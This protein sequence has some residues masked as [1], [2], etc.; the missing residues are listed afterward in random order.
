MDRLGLGKLEGFSDG[1]TVKLLILEGIGVIIAGRTGET[2]GIPVGK[3]DGISVFA[4][5]RNEGI[6]VGEEDGIGVFA[7]GRNE[8]SEVS[9]DDGVRVFADG[10]QEGTEDI[11]PGENDGIG[12]KVV[13]DGFASWVGLIVTLAEGA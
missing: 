8:G 2:E 6:E 4:D 12:A 1:N 10:R 7:D 5:E 9:E 13:G 3:N 11:L